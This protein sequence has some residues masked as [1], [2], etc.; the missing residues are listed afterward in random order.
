MRV[1]SLA[2]CQKRF[3]WTHKEV[4]LAPHSV[5]GLVLQVA[6]AEKFLQASGF[7]SPD[8]FLRVSKQGPCLTAIAEDGG[9]QRLVQLGLSC[10]V[11]SVALPDSVQSGHRCHCWG[12][13]DADFC[14]AAGA[15]F[16]RGCSLLPMEMDV[17][18]SRS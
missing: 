13:H 1:S 17:W 15:I 6:D 11:V 2:G 4:D 3:L 12:N 14:S 8:P 9:D 16:A 7:E 10:E 18:W 5:F